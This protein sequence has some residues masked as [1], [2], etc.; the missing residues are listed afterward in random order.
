MITV[1]VYWKVVTATDMC[2]VILLS[3]TITHFSDD[4][5]LTK[6]A[7][8]GENLNLVS[9]D[10]KTSYISQQS[11]ALYEEGTGVTLFLWAHIVAY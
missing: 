5:C 8:M 6:H 7:V 9:H 1:S 10:H 4:V 3:S 11:Y 2:N